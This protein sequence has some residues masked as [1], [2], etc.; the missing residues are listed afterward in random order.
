MGK[1]GMDRIR[2]SFVSRSCSY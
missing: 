2:N 1:K